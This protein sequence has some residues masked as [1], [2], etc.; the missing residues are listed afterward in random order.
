MNMKAR[1]K[2]SPYAAQGWVPLSN[3]R[4]NQ[5]TPFDK[6]HSNLVSIAKAIHAANEEYVEIVDEYLRWR[7]WSKSKNRFRSSQRSERFSE[8]D[9]DLLKSSV[10]AGPPVSRFVVP[11]L[12][13]KLRETSYIDIW[14]RAAE[15]MAYLKSHPKHQTQRHRDNGKKRAEKI[16]KCRVI[17]ETSFGLVENELRNQGFSSICECILEKVEM[18]RRYEEAYPMSPERSPGLWFKL[19]TPTLLVIVTMSIFISFISMCVAGT[20]ASS[21]PGSTQDSDFWIQIQGAMMQISGLIVAVCNV[22]RGSAENPIA[23]RC[24]LGLTAVGIICAV[25]SIPMY[26]YLPTM[27][28]SIAS[29]AACVTQLI[30]TLELALV[31]DHSKIK[32]S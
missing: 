26:L 10:Q 11:Q 17:V 15:N 12:L 3:N 13:G 28:S 6:Y 9:L 30:V 7:A 25:A 18:L 20:K 1:R 5:M 24:A 8:N 14:R 27:W 2:P 16:K 32:Q 19:P 22:H 21:A 29:F 31:A 23:W 4:Q